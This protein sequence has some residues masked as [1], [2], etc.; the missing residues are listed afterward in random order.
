MLRAQIA[1]REEGSFGIGAAPTLIAAKL[2]NTRLVEP[3]EYGET[4]I[5]LSGIY[6]ITNAIRLAI[7]DKRQLT[8]GEVHMLMASG[9]NFLSGRLTP[10]QVFHSGCR[11]SVW[12]GMGQAMVE[13]ARL[14]LHIHLGLDRLFVE[15]SDDR[16][17]AFAAIEQAIIRWRPVLMLC[18]GARYTVV[19]GFTPT[20]LL[21]FDGGG[22][23]WLSKQ[24]CGVPGDSENMRHLLIPASLMALVA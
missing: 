3:L 1:W 14:K 5:G 22:A 19:S 7:A 10:K 13:A 16:M 17:G 20:S 6:A 23:C 9:F 21:L 4:L 2:A 24:A 8:A 15:A 12:R 11:I 18:R